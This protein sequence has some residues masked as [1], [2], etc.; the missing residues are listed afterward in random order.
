VTETSGGLISSADA[1]SALDDTVA[2]GGFTTSTVET[3][4]TATF[5][6]GDVVQFSATAPYSGDNSNLGLFVVLTHIG[7]TLTIDATAPAANYA[8]T[9][10]VADTS[11]YVTNVSIDKVV[12]TFMQSNPLGVWVTTYGSNITDITNNTSALGSGVNE[13]ITLTG[14]NNQIIFD[15]VSGG[16]NTMTID[17]ESVAGN[18][19]YS[20]PDI[21][22]DADFVLTTGVQTVTNKIVVD[23]ITDHVD[24][25]PTLTINSTIIN[26]FEPTIARAVT[27]P[28]AATAAGYT[29]KFIMKAGAGSVVITRAGADTIE[30]DTTLTLDVIGQH[31]SLTSDGATWR[32]N[33]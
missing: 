27:L 32:I 16:G 4:G 20:I 15:R 9:T 14:D 12:L 22:A 5:A 17:S 28:S 21:G 23:D 3:V 18:V 30:G 29:Y 24:T 25:A 11:S 7:T 31:T 1:A 10:F 26:T 2:A 8:Q 6:A 19:V 33:L 13:T